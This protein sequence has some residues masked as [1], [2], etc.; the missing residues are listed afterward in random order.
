[1]QEIQNSKLQLE[2]L[3]LKSYEVLK[4]VYQEQPILRF[5]SRL[6]EETYL[7]LL[8]NARFW[9]TQ[10]ESTYRYEQGFS[11]MKLNKTKLRSHFTD[12]H[13]DEVMRIATTPL[14]ANV[15]SLA[16]SKHLQKSKFS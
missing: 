3:D 2:L 4:N 7:I 8:K 12:G 15:S 10:F 9:I 16:N 11:I 14:K 13:V 1:M 5:Y 6:E